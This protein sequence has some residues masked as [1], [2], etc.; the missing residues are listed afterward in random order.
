MEPITRIAIFEDNP[1]LREGMSFLL[2][3]TEGFELVG[4]YPDTYDLPERLR[5]SCPDVVLMDIDL[6]GPGGIEATRIIR[7][8]QPGVQIV[9]LTVFEEEEKIF[10]A[11]RNGAAGYLLKAA[12]P[13]E[14]VDAI[15]D[16]RAGGSPL[17]AS[18][19]RKVLQF[20]QQSTIPATKDYQLS[21]RELD[22]LRALMK[23][24]SYK[25]VADELHISIDTVRS[26]IRHIYEKLQVNS[27]S[28]AI[29]K[30]MREGIV[31]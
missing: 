20:F 24:Y 7:E 21:A 8:L 9:I 6:P 12:S 28:E 13:A 3:A 14:I 22:I 18:V 5:H 4:A 19:A 1:H 26:H 17:T 16:A 27:K 25:M 15:L 30:A 23:G 11:I 31:R 2:R 10:Q 29:L